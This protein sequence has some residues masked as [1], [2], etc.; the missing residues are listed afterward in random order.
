MEIKQKPDEIWQ[1]YQ[2]GIMYKQS[3]DLFTTVNRN[4]DFLNDKQWEGVKAPNIDK[5]V[6]NVIKPAVRY[7]I[8]VLISDAIAVDFGASSM[9]N[10]LTGPS[11]MQMYDNKT[12]SRVL[13][14]TTMG[15][16]DVASVNNKSRQFIKNCIVDGDACFYL[17][18]DG[19]LDGVN[20]DVIDSVNVHFG[21]TSNPDAQA[22]PYII[23]AYRRQ[24]AEVKETAKKYGAPAD[25]LETIRPD[26]DNT[27]QNSELDTESDFTTVL[28]K[29]WKE[30][31]TVRAV[32]TT[33]KAVVQPVTDLGYKMYPVVW[34]NWDRR[35]NSFHGISPVS[36]LIPNQIFINKMYALSM[37]YV[38][39][40]AFP[41]VIY[42]EDK[43]PQGWNNDPSSAVAV[44]GDPSQ[45]IFAGFRPPDMGTMPI[46]M[47]DSTMKYTREFAGASDSALGL[48]RPEN[49]SAIIAQQKASAMP[50]DNQRMAFHDAM[51]AAVRCMVDIYSTDYATRFVQLDTGEF[52]NW[53]DYSVLESYELNLSV[54]VGAGSYWSEVTKIQ[55]LEKL[56]DKGMIPP[57]LFVDLIPDGYIADRQKILERM[58]QVQQAQE[59]AAMQQQAG[60]PVQP[61]LPQP[62][63]EAAP[64]G[65][66]TGLAPAELREIMTNLMGA[67][68]PREAFAMLDGMKLPDD[69]KAVL[70]QE[71]ERRAGGG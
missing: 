7:F 57:D 35:K 36:G 26:T 1:E 38:T 52:A 31:G 11:P 42:D 48:E 59:A 3:L 34:M 17:Y 67:G 54:D 9:V 41:K 21:D 49:T 53:F 33:E 24:T 60:G 16:F 28:L 43:L 20:M 2:D 47:A 63:A 29:L 58:I 37:R 56:L 23:L 12:V 44:T 71:L 39:N 55:T 13:H 5:P 66:G 51:E 14:K 10:P 19:V 70:A 45:V 8:S 68:T 50:L 61:E 22:Q 40:F 15:T 18:Y 27:F 25:A 65:G 46:S 6:F 32:R 30:D 62:V 64:Q 69:L 4:N